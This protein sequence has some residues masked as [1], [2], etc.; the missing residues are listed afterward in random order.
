MQT[1]D[2]GCLHTEVNWRRRSETWGSFSL[3]SQFLWTYVNTTITI[4]FMPDCLTEFTLFTFDFINF[5][6]FTVLCVVSNIL[7]MCSSAQISMRHFT[8]CTKL[9]STQFC[10][11]SCCCCWHFQNPV[12]HCKHD[13]RAWG[14]DTRGIKDL[15]CFTIMPCD[16][17]NNLR[18]IC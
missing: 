7:E 12:L 2:Y 14:S 16:H 6:N 1:Q 4:V 5:I 8:S 18:E 17:K 9:T 13:W 10:C 3:F 11:C 15:A